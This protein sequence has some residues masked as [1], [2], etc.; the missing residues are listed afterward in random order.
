M[1]LFKILF[2]LEEKQE[3][4]FFTLFFFSA[5]PMEQLYAPLQLCKAALCFWF[6]F[7]KLLFFTSTLWFLKETEETDKKKECSHTKQS[8]ASPI[9]F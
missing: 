1:L 6:C 9:Y 7:L 8:I 4:S 3:G 2:L 5:Y